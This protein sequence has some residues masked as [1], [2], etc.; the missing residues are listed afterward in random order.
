MDKN[1]AVKKHLGSCHCGDVRFEVEVDATTATRC[2]CSI[3]S[4]IHTTG[5]IVKPAAFKLS[6]DPANT[7]TYEWGTKVGKRFFCKRCGIHCFGTGHLEMLGRDFVSINMNCLDDI[8]PR[9]LK[10][11][12]WDGRNNNWQAGMRDAPWPLELASP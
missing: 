3:C 10:I 5:A 11:G 9:D 2:N 12:Y 7:S 4:K 6:S 8:D 1:E